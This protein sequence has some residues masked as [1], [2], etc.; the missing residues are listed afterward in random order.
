[1]AELAYQVWSCD[2]NMLLNDYQFSAC[3][4]MVKCNDVVLQPLTVFY[5]HRIVRIFY[6]SSQL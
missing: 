3:P 5:H 2:H 6:A 1:M 4:V